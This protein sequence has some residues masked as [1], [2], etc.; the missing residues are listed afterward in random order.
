MHFL[1]LV[2]ARVPKHYIIYIT[3]HYYGILQLALYKPYVIIKYSMVGSKP[4]IFL[5]ARLLCNYRAEKQYGHMSHVF[6]T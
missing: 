5:P 2:L 4:S 6:V 1:S 3:L